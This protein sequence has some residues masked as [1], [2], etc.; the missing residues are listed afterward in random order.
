VPGAF[1]PV[2]VALV[3]AGWATLGLLVA[4]GV[5]PA[6]PAYLVPVGGMVIGN[7]MTAAA[8]ALNRLG[9][10]VAD[11]RRQIEAALALG[12]TGRQAIVPLVRRSLRSGVIPL[13]DSTKTTGLIFF[14][15]TMVG[16][17][18]ARRRTDRRGAPAA[19]AALRPAR[20]GGDRGARRRSAR[21]A[22]VLH[23]GPPAPRARPRWRARGDASHRDSVD[24]TFGREGPRIWKG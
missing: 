13:I 17:L 20:R 4:L 2:L 18:L 14:P 24:A 6:R 12:A 8:V 9:E 21:P 1:W 5:F 3:L 10:D 19:R 16:M 23:A 22:V 15:G 7:A 11:G